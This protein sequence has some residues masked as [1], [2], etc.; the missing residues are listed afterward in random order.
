MKNLQGARNS[1][2]RQR[3]SLSAAVCIASCLCAGANPVYS[4]V[5]V[6]DSYDARLE[7]AIDQYAARQFALAAETFGSLTI[8][9]P[10]RKEAFLWLGHAQSR[11]AKWTEAGAAYQK[12][13][14][15][16]PRD[17]QG[18]RGVGRAY[19][20]QDNTELAR[21][22]YK[23]A[24]ELE[25]ANQDLLS[26]YAELNRQG[27]PQHAP[28]Q[29][30]HKKGDLPAA[31][32]STV[33][34]AAWPSGLAGIF[35]LYAERRGIAIALGLYLLVAA[36]VILHVACSLRVSGAAVPTPILFVSILVGLGVWHVVVWGLQ[37]GWLLIPMLGVPLAGT[38]LCA[39]GSRPRAASD[40][41]S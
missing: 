38:A 2:K 7:Q 36:R 16:S 26:E 8:A 11:L 12:Y 28:G 33:S 27:V 14:A 1:H 19:A 40:F 24:L 35:G 31:P 9:A 18:L 21:T 13:V 22:W 30:E 3:W 39:V 10:E 29:L 17:T 25:P 4:Q 37:G 6:S 20:K 5:A 41:V 34:F 32:F 15:L 23:R